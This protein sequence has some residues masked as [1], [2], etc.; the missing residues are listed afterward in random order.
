MAS[1]SAMSMLPAG[2]ENMQPAEP[3]TI[4]GTPAPGMA[5]PQPPAPTTETFGSLELSDPYMR[6]LMRMYY[7]PP[8]PPPQL[9]F[10]MTNSRY[11]ILLPAEPTTPP[12]SYMR[13]LMRN[14]RPTPT[15][16]IQQSF[17]TTVPTSGNAFFTL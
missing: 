4:P 8:R 15:Q 5:S 16:Q 13:D 3:A 9:S 11:P 14:Y 10:E 17:P 12:S 6:D 7:V 2:M 1:P